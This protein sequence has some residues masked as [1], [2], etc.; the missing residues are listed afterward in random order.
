MTGFHFALSDWFEDKGVD[1]SEQIRFVQRALP[2]LLT[3]IVVL[4]EIREH[5]W[6]DGEGPISRDFLI[7]VIFFGVLGPAAVWF[8]LAWVRS[9]WLERERD[10][11][12]LLQTYQELE[13]AQKR[14]NILNEQRGDLLNRLMHVQEEERR[15][16]SREIHDDLGQLLTGL[17]LN[18]KVCQQSIPPEFEQA[19]ICLSKAN[20]LVQQ[21]ID[22]AHQLMVGL[23]P[24]VLD[25]YGLL[26]ALEEEL[27]QR[28]EPCGIR[29]SIATHG[30]LEH[31]PGPIAT[32][33]FRIT[34]EAVTNVIRHAQATEVSLRIARQQDGIE[35]TIEDNGV[36]IGKERSNNGLNGRHDSSYRPLGIW[37]MQERARGKGGW[38]EVVPR[39][40]R[41]TQVRFWLPLEDEQVEQEVN[42]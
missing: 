26:P 12:N 18:L 34:Q 11:A 31:L 28:L 27:H 20:N 10:R 2:L 39:H 38:L 13:E 8:V 19:H 23:R 29:V 21:T 5:I 32:T 40:P 1:T 17:S 25:D 7:E 16:L 37:G 33:A 6:L 22:Q 9:M 14:L 30:D 35:A 41:G 24:T 4:D 36:G 42:L 3:T 15:H